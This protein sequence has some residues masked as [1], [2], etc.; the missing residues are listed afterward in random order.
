M[1]FTFYAVGGLMLIICMIHMCIFNKKRCFIDRVSDTVVIKM[2]DVSSQ[3][4][5]ASLNSGVKKSKR[6]YGLPGEIIGSPSDEID[7]L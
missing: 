7:G 4:P 5:S 6:N 1:F 2:V 3:D